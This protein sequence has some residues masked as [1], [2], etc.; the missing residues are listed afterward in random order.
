[1]TDFTPISNISRR[2][3]A[4]HVGSNNKRTGAKGN[5]RKSLDQVAIS[6]ESKAQAASKSKEASSVEIRQDLVRKFRNDLKT[7]SYKVKAEE[8]ANKMIQKI[9]EEKDRVIF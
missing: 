8:I 5:F 9:G 4:N 2:N 6:Q 3:L 1:M 7:G